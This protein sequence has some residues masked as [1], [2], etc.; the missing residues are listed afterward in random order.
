MIEGDVRDHADA[1]VE[2]VGGVE[3]PAQS[4]LADE[5]VDAGTR[6]VKERRAGE[7]LELGGRAELRRNLINDGL[8]FRQQCREVGFKRFEVI[9]LA[10]PSSAAIAYK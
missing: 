10:G 9:Q 8:Q 5:Q 2:D 4:H 1:E 6:K 3:A 7:D